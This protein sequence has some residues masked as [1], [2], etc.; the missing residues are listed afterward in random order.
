[1]KDVIIQLVADTREKEDQDE[2]DRGQDIIIAV[3]VGFLGLLEFMAASCSSSF[4]RSC[5]CRFCVVDGR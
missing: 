2:E 5:Y 1:M 3:L 4:A